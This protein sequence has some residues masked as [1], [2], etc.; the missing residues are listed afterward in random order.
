MSVKVFVKIL[1]KKKS[2]LFATKSDFLDAE[3]DLDGPCRSKR[4]KMK[5][6]TTNSRIKTEKTLAKYAATNERIL[7]E[8][9]KDTTE[10]YQWLPKAKTSNSK[11]QQLRIVDRI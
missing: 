9:A 8:E 3:L 4:W 2:E 11:V 7:I 5:S 1:G 6:K 10:P